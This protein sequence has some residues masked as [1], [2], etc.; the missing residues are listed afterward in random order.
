MPLGEADADA[1][2]AI[3]DVEAAA[4]VLDGRCAFVCRPLGG[5]DARDSSSSLE[6]NLCRLRC[7]MAVPSPPA[8]ALLARDATDSGDLDRLRALR[9]SC[10]SWSAC[11]ISW[12]VIGCASLIVASCCGGWMGEA[13]SPEKRSDTRRGRAGGHTRQGAAGARASADHRRTGTARAQASVHVDAGEKE[14]KESST[15]SGADK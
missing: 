12:S 7:G 1:R 4:A 14:P 3:A 6:S 10:L 5:L 15:K 11:L 8:C 2:E 9:L 13:I